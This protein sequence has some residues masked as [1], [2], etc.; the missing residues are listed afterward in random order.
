V[1]HKKQ[2]ALGPMTERFNLM[3]FTDSLILD[4][5]MLRAGK[6]SP[7]DASVRADLAKQVLR[8]VGLVVTAQKFLESNAKEL[9]PA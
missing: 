1:A 2:I 9:P 4:L 3:K 6:I 5:E 8:A 7:R